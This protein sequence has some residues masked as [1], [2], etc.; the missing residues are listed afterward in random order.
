MNHVFLCGSNSFQQIQ[1]LQDCFKSFSDKGDK[2]EEKNSSKQTTR[3]GETAEHQNETSLKKVVTL[4]DNNSIQHAEMTWSR[5]GITVSTGTQSRENIVQNHQHTLVCG[6]S[7]QPSTKPE[8][9]QLTIDKCRL[10]ARNQADFLLQQD[11]DEYVLLKEDSDQV[12]KVKVMTI[13]DGQPE[14]VGCA[15]TFGAM[16]GTAD[17]FI[18]TYDGVS[19]GKLS[20]CCRRRG[21]AHDSGDGSQRSTGLFLTCLDSG[22]SIQHVSCGLEHSVFLTCHGSVLTCGSGSRGQLGHGSLEGEQVPRVL[23]ALEGVRCTVVAAGGWHSAAVTE[24]G[25]LFMWGW[26]ESGQLGLPCPGLRPPCYH[27]PTRQRKQ[28]WEQR[29]LH[30]DQQQPH[31]Q[32][33]HQPKEHQQDSQGLRQQEGHPHDSPQ[34]Q[35]TLQADPQQQ[36]HALH[37]LQSPPQQQQEASQPSDS[38]QPRR[39]GLVCQREYQ[40][41]QQQQQSVYGDAPSVGIAASLHLWPQAVE[42]VG[43]EGDVQGEVVV[44]MVACGSRHTVILT[45]TGDALATGWNK[46]GQLGLPHTDSVDQFWTVTFSE[47]DMKVTQLWCGAWNTMFVVKEAS[48]TE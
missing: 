44:T 12:E 6:Y 7:S 31:Q 13:V 4:G 1:Q 10:L 25:D 27:T 40:Q 2:Y 32:Q 29:P 9:L 33:Q 43:R 20:S 22:L 46:Y 17:E 5:I 30:Q 21:E 8:A 11:D 14:E 28:A 26:N 18:A 23:S 39:Q 38:C 47:K 41:E 3:L 35:Q 37:Q 42:V 36:C 19:V 48:R 34:H 45:E 24:C 15:H 16:S